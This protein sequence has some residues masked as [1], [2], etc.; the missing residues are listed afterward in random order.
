MR[1]FLP[2][3][4]RRSCASRAPRAARPALAAAVLILSLTGCVG[5]EQSRLNM[6][7]AA[8]GNLYGSTV[9]GSL[10]TDPAFFPNKKMKITIRNTS[11][12]Q[13]FD[14]AG[15]RGDLSRAYDAK[16]YTEAGASDFGLKI[17]VNVRYSGHIQENMQ[18]QFAFLGAAAGG[19]QG[20]RSQASYGAAMGTV[21]GATLGAIIGSFITQ[22]TYIVVATVHVGVREPHAKHK[23]VITFD[24]SP[25]SV[26]DEDTGFGRWRETKTIEIAVYGGGTNVN[27]RQIAAEVRRRIVRI[28]SDII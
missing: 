7:R 22:D 6:V 5:A 10:F 27:Q 1:H 4:I 2:S 20:A 24:R 15:F 8:D 28:A 26:T 19:I 14:L 12:D 11:G 17:D 16:G 23:K 18:Q 21:G 13:A 3:S 9:S 25:K